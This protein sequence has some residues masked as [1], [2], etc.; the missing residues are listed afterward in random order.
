MAH[1]IRPV[2][3]YEATVRDIP[4]EAYQILQVLAS[5]QVSLI[6]FNAVPAGPDH[7]LLTLFPVE[8]KKLVAVAAESGLELLG[9]RHGFLIQGDDQLGA[10]VDIHRRLYEADINIASAS[11]VSDGRGGF[12]YI[13]LVPDEDYEVAAQILE[14]A[15]RAAFRG[16]N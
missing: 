8:P 10:L 12:G 2:H 4:G 9:P 15:L 11:G 5:S 13:V 3:F 16:T 1:R 14:R 7:S 6:A